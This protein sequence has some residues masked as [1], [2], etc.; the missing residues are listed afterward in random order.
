MSSGLGRRADA[1]AE[2]VVEVAQALLH[3]RLCIGGA[4]LLALEG[5][6]ARRRFAAVLIGFFLALL[7]LDLEIAG[8]REPAALVVRLRALTAFLLRRDA[9]ASAG[10]VGVEAAL[11]VD[12]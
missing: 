4:L 1:D 8:A 5:L 12:L 6:H 3:L 7:E 2:T 11:E 10:G 9:L